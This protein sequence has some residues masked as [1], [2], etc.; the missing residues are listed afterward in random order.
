MG[1]L[2]FINRLFSEPEKARILAAR[3]QETKRIQKEAE[4]ELKPV[5]KL[6]LNEMSTTIL[7]TFWNFQIIHLRSK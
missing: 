2:T 5:L 1:I 3:E 4:G 7:D 6:N